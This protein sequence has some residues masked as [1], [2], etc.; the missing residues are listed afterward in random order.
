MGVV[1]NSVVEWNRFDLEYCHCVDDVKG[2][3]LRY[4]APLEA[5]IWRGICN[6]TYC[7]VSV[8]SDGVNGEAKTAAKPDKFKLRGAAGYQYSNTD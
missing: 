4:V 7:F 3:I 2:L 5:F 8:L 1:I 6:C